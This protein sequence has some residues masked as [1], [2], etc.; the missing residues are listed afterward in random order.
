MTSTCGQLLGLRMG[1]LFDGGN[2]WAKLRAWLLPAEDQLRVH[3]FGLLLAVAGLCV[4]AASC[5]KLPGAL[6]L[7]HLHNTPASFSLKP[8]GGAGGKG[9]FGE[10]E[11]MLRER[12]EVLAHANYEI[13]AS[14]SASRH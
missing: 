11:S 5:K 10:L 3:C 7:V 12:G 13:R 4:S 1:G 8:K 14:I 2:L 9:R 6:G